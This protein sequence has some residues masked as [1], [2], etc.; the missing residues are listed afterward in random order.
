MTRV[1]QLIRVIC[2]GSS[3]RRGPVLLD[4]RCPSPRISVAVFCV[5]QK[6]DVWLLAS[7][8]APFAMK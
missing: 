7:S 4:S 6:F 1:A 5:G 8:L 2:K 3:R